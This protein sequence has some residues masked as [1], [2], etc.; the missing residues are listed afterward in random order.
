MRAI[1]WDGR[2]IVA[3]ILNVKGSPYEEIRSTNVKELK[4]NM[5]ISIYLQNERTDI[6]RSLL[7]S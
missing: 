1:A 4:K 5:N 7:S 2:K 6:A 3:V